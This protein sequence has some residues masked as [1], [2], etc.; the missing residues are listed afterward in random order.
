MESH[1]TAAAEFAPQ[2]SRH[3][4]SAPGDRCFLLPFPASQMGE[5]ALREQ[6]TLS[7]RVLIKT[8]VGGNFQRFHSDSEGL[9]VDAN[10]G[11]DYPNAIRRCACRDGGFSD[12]RGTTQGLLAVWRASPRTPSQ[13]NPSPLATVSSVQAVVQ[14]PGTKVGNRSVGWVPILTGQAVLGKAPTRMR[15]LDLVITCGKTVQWK[16]CRS[17]SPQCR[18]ERLFWGHVPVCVTLPT[19]GYPLGLF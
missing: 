5:S 6:R 16:L 17:P 8:S 19:A 14:M 10:M 2:M 1:L 9:G 13:T 18:A 15:P 12:G 3:S 11:Y 4:S 7:P